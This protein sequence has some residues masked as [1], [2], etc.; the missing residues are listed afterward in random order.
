MYLSRLEAYGFKSFAQ[1]LDL[2]F[3]SGITCVVGPNGCGKSNV[4]DALRWALGEQR[5]RSLRSSNMT[6]VIFS[7]TRSRKPLGMAEVS[8]T[9]DNSKKLLPTDFAEVTVTRRL[10]RSGESDYL[11]NK[12]PCRL[13]DIQNL[14]MDTG[15]GAQS[16]YVIEQGMV[17]EIISD[18][19]EERRRVFEEAAGVTRYKIR[20]RSAWNK[21]I[22]I[23][24]D[25][26]RIADII[27]EVERQVASLQRQERKARLYK[28]VSDELQTLEIAL[29]RFRYFD[30]S[31][32]A[33]PMLE[34]MSFL[35]EDVEVGETDMAGLEARLEALRME[36]T[37]QDQALSA[38]NMA[39]SQQ[40]DL[41]HRKDREI[42]VAREEVR[43]IKG[44]L[45]RASGQRKT[46]GLRQQEAR[47]GQATAEKGLVEAED[48]LKG[49]ETALEA[50]MTA[51]EKATEELDAHRAKADDQKRR[52]IALLREGSEQGKGLE[53]LRAEQD[54]AQERSARL[55]DD[56][57]RVGALRTEADG[58]VRAAGDQIETIER[59]IQAHTETRTAH[60]EARDRLQA[61]RDD[62]VEQ[63]NRTRARL[64]A[65]EA[66]MALLVK[67]KEGFEGYSKGV[68]ALAVDSPF[69]A[70]I[71]GVVADLVQVDSVH[72][73]AIESALGQ[74][75]ECLLV[76]ATDDALEAMDYLRTGSYGA[77][78]FLPVERILQPSGTPWKA[79]EED[80]VIGRASDLLVGGSDG[81][82]R[83]LLRQT[84]VVKD[85][86]TALAV[87][88]QMRAIGV[89]LVTLSGEVFAANGTVFGGAEA[90]AESG[91]VGRTQQIASLEADL[92]DGRDRLDHLEGQIQRVGEA[93]NGEVARIASEDGVLAHLQNRRAGLQRDR[94]NASVEVQRQTQR[95]TELEEEVARLKD[96]FEVRTRLIAEEEASLKA[97]EEQRGQLEGAARTSDAVLQE[98]ELKRRNQ[99]DAVS[100]RRVEIASLKERLENLRLTKD[101]LEKEQVSIGEELDR[102]SRECA[103]SERRKGER[104]TAIERASEEL[105]ELH[106]VQTEVEQRRDSQAQQ[107]QELMANARGLEDGLREKGRK[108]TQSR[109]RLSELQVG[110]VELKTRG[111]EL[112]ERLKRDYEVDVEAMNR[113]DDPEFSADITDK[114]IQELQERLRRMGSVNLAALEEYEVQKARYEFL[115]GE[116][117]DVLEAEAILKRTI[118]KIDRTARGRFLD[119]FAKIRE[120]FHWTF[121]QFFEGGE[122]DLMIPPDE[123]PLEAPLLITARP[124][125]K[126]LQSINLLSGGERALTAIAL[127][128][129]I[130]LVKPSP[131]CILDEVD[132]PLDDANVDRFVRVVRQF[133]EHSQFIV[134]THNKRTMECAD[135]LHGVTM[136][137]PGVSKLVSVRM[138]SKEEIE[139]DQVDMLTEAPAPADDD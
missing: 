56:V 114:K 42:L 93:L 71:R 113:L 121:Q 54:G 106:R 120:H 75:L 16:S 34:E 81:A 95:G 129:A 137:E 124:R 138:G 123:D 100:G 23:Q 91:L 37:E 46:L 90:H 97:V 40:V 79:P 29:A 84:L 8:V 35:K 82:V 24:G 68:R 92:A 14:L 73:V 98:Q 31:D 111:E 1:K 43:S 85:V 13:K 25:L 65:D 26:Q 15:L 107:Q 3:E 104:E 11:L 78:A 105:K 2:P 39:V 116:R 10:F 41:V 38:A 50:E 44:F 64:E 45:E 133:S 96:G 62:L 87:T 5:P 109:D 76:D 17:D 28:Q 32:R 127:L 58:A 77:A 20:R 27:G 74:V 36:L 57:A 30:M 66:R 83:A 60:V 88:P 52:L 70:R 119:T 72:L 22:S 101:R 102:L 103:S 7:G 63:R 61:E 115:V 4:V 125:G 117:D 18:N 139:P 80:G 131:F 67:L 122:A 47:E 89:D 69:S 136:E 134:V 59:E 130:Y 12:I 48:R 94:Q 135:C 51:L 53:R 126:Q 112:L 19:A 55:H 33:R 86:E 128:F 108:M 6:E 118:Q 110:M 99:Q 9:L 49:M 132:A 21:L